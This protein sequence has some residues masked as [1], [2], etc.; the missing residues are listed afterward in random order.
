MPTFQGY[1]THLFLDDEIFTIE[2]NGALK[3]F[4]G[5]TCEFN[6]SYKAY[7]YMEKGRNSMGK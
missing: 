2:D 4:R 3:R 6:L 5:G 7:L 1:R